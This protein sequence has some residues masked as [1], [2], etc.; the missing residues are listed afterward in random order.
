MNESI[1]SVLLHKIR[2]YG[3]HCKR[4]AALE[5]LVAI[6]LASDAPI[7]KITDTRVRLQSASIDR[8]REYVEISCMLRSHIREQS[9]LNHESGPFAPGTK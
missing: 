2:D 6:Q 5:D 9:T 3:K 7:E 1:Y 4:C 8:D